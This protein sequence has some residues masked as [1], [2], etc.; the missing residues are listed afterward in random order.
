MKSQAKIP[1][2]RFLFMI[3]GCLK[4]QIISSI[5]NSANQLLLNEL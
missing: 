5:L 3:R 2:V 1:K 4:K